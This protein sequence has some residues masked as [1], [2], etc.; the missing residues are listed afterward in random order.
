MNTTKISIIVPV[1]KVEPYL[2]R[3]VDSLLEQTYKNIEVILVDD[4]SPDK[5]P[6]ICDE[7][8]QRDKRVKV[9]HKPN[10]GLSS[11]RNAGLDYPLQGDY[12]AFLDSDDW[13]DK[14]T[15][16]YCTDLLRVKNAQAV[17][18]GM[19][20]VEVS[21][22][23]YKQPKEKIAVY[24]GK[25]VLQYY[26]K[27]STE[28]S[29]EYSVCIGVYHRSLFVGIRFREGKI[30]EDIDFK[31][32]LM[33]RCNS[34]VVSNQIKYNYFQ[35]GNTISMGGLK[36]K[37]FQLREA[38][39]LLAELSAKESYGNIAYLGKVKQA[40]TAFS[41]LSKIA[42]FG[43][44]DPAIDKK[45]TVKE[46]ALEHRENLGVLLRSPMTVSRKILAIM[47]A[48]NFNMTEMAIQLIKKI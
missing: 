35:T 6:E 8:A 48:I 11:A 31:Y 16:A 21:E 20:L 13:V 25:D 4:G 33:S 40:R 2:K 45:E 30:N 43:V 29:E 24:K 36:K 7:Y 15:Y 28:D 14:D 18:F 37:D 3:C 1:Y 26:M 32:R 10:G 42:Y 17:Q 27:H 38:G 19:R 46:L 47:F 22:G 9:I 5:C 39:D 23:T 41:L 12:V 44:A 34:L